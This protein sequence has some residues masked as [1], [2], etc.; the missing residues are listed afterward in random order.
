[1]QMPGPILPTRHVTSYSTAA[2]GLWTIFPTIP[3]VCPGISTTFGPLNKHLTDKLLVKE[4]CHLLTKENLTVIQW[5]TTL[6]A[7]GSKCF[8]FS[9]DYVEILCVPPATHVPYIFGTQNK[10]NDIIMFVTLF[11]ETYLYTSRCC[12]TGGRSWYHY[13]NSYKNRT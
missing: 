8:Y 9:S 1:M 13:L 2:A 4:C 5:D 3:I 7:E 12:I 10:V 11:L 6:G